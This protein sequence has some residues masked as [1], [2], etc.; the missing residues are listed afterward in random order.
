[1]SEWTLQR[2][3]PLTLVFGLIT[4]AAAIV[5][6]VSVMMSDIASNTDDIAEVQGRLK[7]L[8]TTIQGQAVSLATIDANIGH[9]REAVERM[10]SN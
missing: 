6:T 3:V 8:E 9:I 2:T 10:A 1:M 4:Q 5:W 7:L